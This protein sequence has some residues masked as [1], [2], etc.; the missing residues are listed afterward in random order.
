MLPRVVL[1][2]AKK[3]ADPVYRRQFSRASV[4]ADI[5]RQLIALR[6]L[7]G[8]TQDEVA[9]L[10]QTKQSAISRS[11]SANYHGMSI[12]TLTSIASAMNGRVIIQIVPWEDAPIAEPRYLDSDEQK[13]MHRALK[14]SV[15]FV[16]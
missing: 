10:A 5:A 6:K 7:R 2:I 12:A 15:K 1:N 13:I 4:S 11:E 3:L 9:E 14:R 16:K 8:M